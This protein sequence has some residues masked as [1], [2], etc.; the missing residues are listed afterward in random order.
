MIRLTKNTISYYHI[1]ETLVI[2]TNDAVRHKQKE[3]TI[4]H[5]QSILK[6]CPIQRYQMWIA[7]N[8][9]FFKIRYAT[10]L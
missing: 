4:Y 5:Q 7:E 9:G 8:R 3:N 6:A 1:K 10:V 2:E